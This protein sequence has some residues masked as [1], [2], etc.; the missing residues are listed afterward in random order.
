MHQLVLSSAFQKQLKKLIKQNPHLKNQIAKTL[1][2]LQS[3][4]KHQ[5]LRLHKLEGIN[6]WSVYVNKNLRII[7]HWEKDQLFL[8][9]IAPHD[10]SYR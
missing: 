4:L 1:K 10:Q 8:L 7:V 6:S 2:L 9:R 5:S 3:N